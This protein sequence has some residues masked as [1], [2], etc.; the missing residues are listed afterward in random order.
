MTLV[1]VIAAGFLCACGT[2]LVL[3]R[4]LSRVI[5]GIGLLGHGANILLLG[6]GGRGGDPAFVGPGAPTDPGDPL[7]QALVLTAIVISFGMTALAVVL[8]LRSYLETGSERVDEPVAE[9][10]TDAEARP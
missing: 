1:L 2:Y 10:A 6:S 3:G 8:A 4:Q 7:P 5:I 9:D